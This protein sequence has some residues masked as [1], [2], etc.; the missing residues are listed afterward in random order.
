MEDLLTKLFDATEKGEINKVK[1]ILHKQQGLID[2]ENEHGLTLLGIAAHFGQFEVVKSLVKHGAK[3]N[4]ISHS[5][6]SFIPKNT[7]LHAA[8][9]GAKS[10][11][12]IEFLLTNGADPN[13]TDSEGHTALHIAAFEGNIAIAKL[14]IMN[15]AKIKN[16][17]SGKTPLEIAEERGNSEF[18]SFIKEVTI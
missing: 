2:K 16:N 5:K 12:V 6:L 15:G 13:I 1:E 9:A 3:I 17:N 8:I 11:E 7:A 18:I 4:A 10:K 14:L